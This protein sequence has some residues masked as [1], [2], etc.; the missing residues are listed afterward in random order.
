MSVWAA[1]ASH[2]L[3]LPTPI[4]NPLLS[5]L[6]LKDPE[7][8]NG[9]TARPKE[10]LPH[11]ASLATLHSTPTDPEGSPGHHRQLCFWGVPKGTPRRVAPGPVTPWMNTAVKGK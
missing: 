8:D 4:P 1:W 7:G 11:R 9:L 6:A 2:C 5:L 3:Q 10:V